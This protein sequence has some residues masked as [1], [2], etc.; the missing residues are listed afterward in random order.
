MHFPLLSIAV[1][2]APVCPCKDI[3]MSNGLLYKFD[4]EQCF[5]D[6]EVF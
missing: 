2:K 6:L 3:L 5:S 4:I 1:A